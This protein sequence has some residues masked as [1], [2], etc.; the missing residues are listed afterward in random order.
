[1]NSRTPKTIEEDMAATDQTYRNQKILDIVFAVTCVLMLVSIIWMFVQDYNREFKH[2][3]RKFRDV[4]EAL[5]ERQ[6]L[7]KLPDVEQVKEASAQRAEAA[8][9]LQQVKYDSQSTTRPLLAEKAQRE[10]DF[11]KIKA[12]Y[13]SKMSLYNLAVENRDEG[14]SERQ[15]AL[16]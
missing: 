3:Q 14:E 11:Q 6:L 16:Q 1:M 5:T 12:E 8:A 4:D 15:P 7:E 2:V 10:A 13:D 9:K